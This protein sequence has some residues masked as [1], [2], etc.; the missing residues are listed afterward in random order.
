MIDTLVWIWDFGL[1]WLVMVGF[2]VVVGFGCCGYFGDFD[3]FDGSY[4]LF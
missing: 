2:E 4:L 1:V 3:C